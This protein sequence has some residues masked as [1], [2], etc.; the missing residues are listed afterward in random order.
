[1][2]GLLRVNLN[3]GR[4]QTVLRI[5]P[6][7][8]A[9]PGPPF[10]DA[11]PTNVRAYG[12]FLLIS[13]LTGFP[14]GSATASVLIYD[15]ATGS[16]APFIKFL[17]AAMDVVWRDRP[18]RPQFFTAEFSLALAAT[19]PLPGRLQRYD[20][21]DSIVVSSQLITPS[22]LAIDPDNG[23]VFITELGTGRI[24]RYRQ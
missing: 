6:F 23:D 21:A 15:P 3:T 11:V 9:V 12:D 5:R 17:T 7:A 20:T 2:N 24:L 1:M 4:A 22:S 19:P 16:V 13:C 18:G 8:S 10:V 14:F